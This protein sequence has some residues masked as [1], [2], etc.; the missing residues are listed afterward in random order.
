MLRVPPTVA[1]QVTGAGITELAWAP[2]LTRP[3]VAWRRLGTPEFRAATFRDGLHECPRKVLLGALKGK[4][5]LSIASAR[6]T[7]LS[8]KENPTIVLL[9][10]HGLTRILNVWHGIQRYWV[11]A[12]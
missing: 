1:A 12:S 5:P 4:G 7:N 6:D 2:R 8:T 10:V 9:L 3:A 11:A